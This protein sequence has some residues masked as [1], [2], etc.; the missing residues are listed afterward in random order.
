MVTDQDHVKCANDL[1]GM[2]AAYYDVEDL[3]SVGAYKPGSQP[4]SDR[5]LD[6]WDQVNAFLRQDKSEATDAKDT[7]TV[8]KRLTDG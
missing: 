3:V 5:A 2:V 4:R 1:R 7:L 8:L 6:R